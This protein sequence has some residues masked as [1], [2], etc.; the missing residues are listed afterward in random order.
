MIH[1]ENTKIILSFMT[2]L[3]FF[4]FF[5]VVLNI[6]HLYFIKTPDSKVETNLYLFIE[7][8]FISSLIIIFVDLR[9]KLY[10]KKQMM[11]FLKKEINI[12]AS[13]V[14]LLSLTVMYL[15]AISLHT[16]PQRNGGIPPISIYY[17]NLIVIEIILFIII[18]EIRKGIEIIAL[19]IYKRRIKKQ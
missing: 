18:N 16:I 1:N 3:L 9:Y 2:L 8:T 12:V 17:A 13:V 11:F 6:F 5:F 19:F 10:N 15:S 14:L 4:V 7:T